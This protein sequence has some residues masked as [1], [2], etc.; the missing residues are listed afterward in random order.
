MY[1]S[2]GDI[3]YKKKVS[4]M[5]DPS[6]NTVILDASEDVSA[7]V[8]SDGIGDVNWLAQLGLDV[9]HYITKG[10]TEDEIAQAILQKSITNAVVSQYGKIVPFPSQAPRP[11]WDDMSGSIVRIR[12][13]PCES[14]K[15]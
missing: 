11:K 3:Y 6:V 5:C 15:S 4:L 8:F 2:V 12:S 9:V 14:E 10:K 7:I 1:K 13:E